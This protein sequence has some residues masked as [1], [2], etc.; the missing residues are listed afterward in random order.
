[1]DSILEDCIDEGYVSLHVYVWISMNR[2]GVIWIYS[3]LMV[4]TVSQD[5]R[6]FY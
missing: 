4:L 2:V 1:M 3:D 6:L 5:V